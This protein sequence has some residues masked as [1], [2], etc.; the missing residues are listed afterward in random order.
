MVG[1][2]L[3][4]SGNIETKATFLVKQYNLK[5][6]YVRTGHPVNSYST[7]KQIGGSICAESWGVHPYYKKGNALLC[8]SHLKL[9]LRMQGYLY[10]YVALNDQL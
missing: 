6:L 9:T 8:C 1:H 5:V 2:L 7:N 3:T 10:V 4:V